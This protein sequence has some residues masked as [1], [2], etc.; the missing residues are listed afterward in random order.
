[1]GKQVRAS[2]ACLA[3]CSRSHPPGYWPRL[4]RIVHERTAHR[5]PSVCGIAGILNLAD[6]AK[7]AGFSIASGTRAGGN[8]RVQLR[9]TPRF[10]QYQIPREVPVQP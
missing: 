2:D 3:R 4:A 9:S 10:Y 5:P 7:E 1:M 8:V 6:G